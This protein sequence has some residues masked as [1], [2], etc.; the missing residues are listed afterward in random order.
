MDIQRILFSHKNIKDKTIF[1][2]KN[3]QSKN[4]SPIEKERKNLIGSVYEIGTLGFVDE[5]KK[6]SSSYVP[7]VNDFNFVSFEEINN[8]FNNNYQSLDETSIWNLLI[9][10]EIN[11]LLINL[12]KSNNEYVI[13]REVTE[14]IKN[15]LIIKEDFRIGIIHSNLGNGK[16]IVATNLSYLLSDRYD[17]YMFKEYSENIDLE[18]D[19]IRNKEN[20]VVVIENYQ[21][22]LDLIERIIKQTNKNCKLILTSRTF[23]NNSTYYKLNE[24]K[25]KSDLIIEYNI[26]NLKTKEIQNL[27]KYIRQRKFDKTFNLSLKNIELI[28]SKNCHKR[29]SEVLLYLLESKNIR[30]KIDE[31]VNPL[32]KNKMKKD[33][34]LALVISNTCSLDLEFDDLVVLLDLHTE[35]NLIIRDPD[36]NEFLDIHNGKIKL[37]SSVLS[38]YIMSTREMN[39]DVIEV[40]KKIILNADKLIET[41]KKSNIRK[42]LISNSNIREI[43]T[44][45]PRENVAEVNKYIL[46]YFE[47]LTEVKEFKENIF[48]W[49]QYAM[50]CIDA[51]ELDRA[52]NYFKNSYNLTYEGFN[53]F[54]ID[55]QYGRFFL[56]YGLQKGVKLESFY[57]FKE[58][59]K[60]LNK[61]LRNKPEQSYYVFKQTYLI[62]EII[63]KKSIYW[64]SEMR[65]QAYKACD[66]LKKDIMKDNRYES[67]I[68]YI[69]RAL[70]K[71]LESSAIN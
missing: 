27:A 11:P 69:E 16:T 63:D 2:D 23:I 44:E 45:T 9:N 40:M 35:L 71:L 3:V 6:I 43:I 29:I 51:R 39:K 25:N 17:V 65:R 62:T 30:N 38:K 21:N 5:I 50:A 14:E 53:T 61:A 48:F 10:G 36:I 41:N 60:Y 32:M 70:V 13:S 37:K 58:A 18:I 12:N 57:Y 46:K 24:F 49:L 4:I 66:K 26:N 1:I 68:K 8:K 56:E 67:F 59:I 42:L 15:D 33:I 20:S 64:D 34:L 7:I 47:D 54:Q 19:K 22:H 28:I 52:E 55:T 31:I